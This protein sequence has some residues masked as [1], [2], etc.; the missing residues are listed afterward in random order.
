MNQSVKLYESS[1]RLEHARIVRVLTNHLT[2]RAGLFAGFSAHAHAHAHAHSGAG[3]SLALL[4]PSETN[5]PRI[6]RRLLPIIARLKWSMRRDRL[7]SRVR[8]SSAN[9]PDGLRSWIEGSGRALVHEGE[10]IR[11]AV[12]P[13]VRKFV[14]LFEELSA[15]GGHK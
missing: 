14:K 6:S 1:L 10:R 4:L 9:R 7:A 11:L 12:C 13:G 2:N 5:S 8:R 15:S 3:A